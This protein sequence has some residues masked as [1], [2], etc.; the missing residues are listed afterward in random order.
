MSK[1]LS[2]KESSK[3]LS[4]VQA[5][6]IEN[7]GNQEKRVNVLKN[8]KSIF[9]NVI[10]VTVLGDGNEFF[11]VN[12]FWE[13]VNFSYKE[14]GLYGKYRTDYNKMTYNSSTLSIYSD[15]VIIGIS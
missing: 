14:N 4:A 15:N 3:S 1:K 6:K 10:T 12:I 8:N 13:E 7:P 5:Y 9:N 11:D 2:A